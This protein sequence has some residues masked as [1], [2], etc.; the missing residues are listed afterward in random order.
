MLPRVPAILLHL[1][2][3]PSL[4]F[5]HSVVEPS[6]TFLHP[7][8]RV[9]APSI[10]LHLVVEPS[11]TF[12]HPVERVVVPSIFLHPVKGSICMADVVHYQSSLRGRSRAGNLHSL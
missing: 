2:A 3:E 6:P 9:V 4:T 12:L 10:L 8:E 5:L 7:V 11:P 1:V